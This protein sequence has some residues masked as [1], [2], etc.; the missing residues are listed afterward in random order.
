MT[1]K[2]VDIDYDRFAD[3]LYLSIGEPDRRARSTEGPEGVI[4]RNSPEG[5]A[6]GVTVR[7]FHQW[8]SERRVELVDLLA[9]TLGLSKTTLDRKLPELVA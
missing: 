9:A 7:N 6:Q 8:W 3:V 1:S 4:W 5:E 2:P